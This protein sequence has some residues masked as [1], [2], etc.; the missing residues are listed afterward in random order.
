M[1]I[2][3]AILY[4]ALLLT[5]MPC[6]ALIEQ[7]TRWIN[8]SGQEVNIL[9]DCHFDTMDY[10]TTDIQHAIIC[11]RDSF[12]IVEDKRRSCLHGDM[13]DK[14]FLQKLRC[15][16]LFI[17]KIT[18]MDSTDQKAHLPADY[19][20]AYQ[21]SVLCGLSN[22]PQTYNAEFRFSLRGE[23]Y[24]SKIR[25]EILNTLNEIVRYDDGE[26]LNQY[27]QS[28]IKQKEVI[29]STECLCTDENLNR[30]V[31]YI[32][33]DT[34]EARI[35]HAL[36]NNPKQPT[37]DI[38]AGGNHCEYIENM[39]A[40]LGYIKVETIGSIS[41]PIDYNEKLLAL[42]TVIDIEQVLKKPLTPLSLYKK[43]CLRIAPFLKSISRKMQLYK[44]RFR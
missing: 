20:Q 41:K 43:C 16:D 37:I 19:E 21:G 10:I 34:L 28:I 18:P 23:I 29:D 35:L 4:S 44:A 38:I 31:E 5:T 14:D 26:I 32:F 9:H 27:Y 8:I 39:M 36:Y 40:S 42:I 17:K 11:A 12:K 24:E 13:I 2:K 1:R 33:L 30:D 22:L 6:Y 7:I 15:N 25:E 3:H